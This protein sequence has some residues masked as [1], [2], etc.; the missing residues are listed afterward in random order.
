MIYHPVVQRRWFCDS[1]NQHLDPPR[2]AQRN[3]VPYCEAYSQY[4]EDHTHLDIVIDIP[5]DKRPLPRAIYTS[6]KLMAT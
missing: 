6:E 3:P 5:S 2:P 4:P 1:P